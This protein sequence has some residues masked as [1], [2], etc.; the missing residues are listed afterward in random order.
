MSDPG[1][2]MAL[3]SGNLFWRIVDEDVVALDF[4]GS[5]YFATNSAG[6]LLWSRLQSGATRA[7]L[8]GAMC[9]RYSIDAEQAG[10]EVD[11]FV[12]QLASRG[13]LE[14]GQG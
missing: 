13:L 7:E 4:T 11:D 1:T 6:T 3:R 8:I 5:R 9:D 10:R 12:A 2:R 14:S